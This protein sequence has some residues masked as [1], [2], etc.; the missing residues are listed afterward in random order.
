MPVE[1]V[2]PPRVARA[3]ER[4]FPWVPS[5][6]KGLRGGPVYFVALSVRSAISRDGD[7]RDGEGYYFH[8]A[9]IA[10]DPSYASSVRVV[11][12]RLGRPGPRTVLGF[13]TDGANHCT[14]TTPV[15]NCGNRLHRFAPRLQIATR[16]GWR[17]VETELRIGRTGCFRVTA[18][19]RHLH[20]EIP[21][22][23]PGPD[24]GTPGW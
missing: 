2:S 6:G 16:H 4:F 21:L 23:V 17:I 24:W 10:V 5:A 1:Q 13:S 15:V 18:T 14:V 19:G 12:K 11:G 20:A 8:R 22:A 3:A 7:R 9:L